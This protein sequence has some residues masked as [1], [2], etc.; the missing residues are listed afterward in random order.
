MVPNAVAGG[1]GGGALGVTPAETASALKGARVSAWRMETFTTTDGVHVINDA[2][3]AN[4]QSMAAALQT[5]RL[6]ARESRLVVVLGH[7]AELGPISGQEHLRVG[8]LVARVEAD[9]LITVGP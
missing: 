8:E 7:M 2:Y 9:R 5:A 4:P 1:A 3:N 6:L